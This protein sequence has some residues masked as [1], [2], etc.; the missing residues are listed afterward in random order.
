MK[1]LE[2]LQVD[3]LH[4]KLV[5]LEEAARRASHTSKDSFGIV[6]QRFTYCRGLP[7]VGQLILNLLSTMEEA[8]VLEKEGKFL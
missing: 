4:H 3:V 7:S 8:A 2:L 5:R 6:L 1:R